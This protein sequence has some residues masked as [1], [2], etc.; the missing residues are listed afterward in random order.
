MW[1]Y[2]IWLGLP[3]ARVVRCGGSAGGAVEREERGVSC[4]FRVGG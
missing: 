2:L 4:D 3:W 1:T